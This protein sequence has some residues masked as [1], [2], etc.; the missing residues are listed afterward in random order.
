[1]S[2]Q[3][4]INIYGEKAG[5]RLYGTSERWERGEVDLEKDEII[6]H[7]TED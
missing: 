6:W 3:E 5:T 4:F 2:L 7:K 1:M